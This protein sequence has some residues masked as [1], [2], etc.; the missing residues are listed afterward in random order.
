MI[1]DHELKIVKE[2]TTWRVSFKKG[3]TNKEA[4]LENLDDLSAYIQKWL[5]TCQE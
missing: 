2:G 4:L 5:E 1:T 3:T